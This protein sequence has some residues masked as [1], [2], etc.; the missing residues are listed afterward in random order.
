MVGTSSLGRTVNGLSSPAADT[1]LLI[2]PS[3]DLG[4]SVMS[5]GI[6]LEGKRNSEVVPE[7]PSLSEVELKLGVL[8][9]V[10]APDGRRWRVFRSIV[11][12]VACK[13]GLWALC[14]L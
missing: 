13:G 1:G 10:D 14:S 12:P 5:R 2:V 7:L 6:V 11:W 8:G 4:R 9:T 3:M